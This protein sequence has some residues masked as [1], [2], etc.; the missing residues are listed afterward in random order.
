M[1][2]KSFIIS[3]LNYCPMVWMCHGRGLDNIINN[4]H[5]RV[6]RIVF[7]DKRSSFETLLKRDKST[8]IRTKNLQY[9]PA[10][11]FKV[12]NELSP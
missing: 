11:L 9:L 2:F 1:L 7:Q 4:I 6:L 8:W 10:E 5:E 12:N 3:Q